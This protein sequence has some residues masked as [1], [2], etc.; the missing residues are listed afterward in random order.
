MLT[1]SNQA[2][3]WRALSRGTQHGRLQPGH[4]RV[5]TAHQAEQKAPI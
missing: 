1:L 2:Q 3:A 4:A 5:T